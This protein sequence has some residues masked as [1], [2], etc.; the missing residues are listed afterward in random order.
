MGAGNLQGAEGCWAAQ[1][2]APCVCPHRI[3]AV[4]AQQSGLGCPDLSYFLCT[5]CVVRLT[6]TPPAD[7]TWLPGCPDLSSVFAYPL[8]GAA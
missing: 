5:C 7:Q 8:R 4:R 6:L 2:L 3:A 1:V